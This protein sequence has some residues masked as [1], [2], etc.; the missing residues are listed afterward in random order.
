MRLELLLGEFVGMREDDEDVGFETVLV[1]VT[2]V[3][4]GFIVWG[5]FA[6]EI[7]MHEHAEE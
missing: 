2:V 6:V 3:V 5:A 1:T 7:P 4:W